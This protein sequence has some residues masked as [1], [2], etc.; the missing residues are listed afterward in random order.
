MSV[1][2]VFEIDDLRKNILS[3]IVIN[4]CISCHKNL[5]SDKKIDLI[6]YKNYRNNLWRSNR[7]LYMKN[8]CNWCYYYVYE[9]PY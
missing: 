9:Y 5:R 1:Q 7:N 3:Y 2:R 8:V 4:R 6:H